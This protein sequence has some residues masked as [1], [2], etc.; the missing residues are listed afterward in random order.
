MRAAKSARR[1]ARVGAGI[2]SALLLA[3]TGAPSAVADAPPDAPRDPRWVD[4]PY[5]PHHTTG[6]NV[7]LGSAV[8]Y[9][10]H[11]TK[12][13]TALGA[14]VAAGPR[15]GRFTFEADYLFLNLSEPGP[16]ALRYGRAQRLGA[17]ARVDVVR[18]GSRVLGANSMLAIYAELGAAR[19]WHAWSR[20]GLRDPARAVPV[21]SAANLGVVGFGVNLD[22]RL[23]QPLNLSR[24]GWQ[25]GWQLT[26]TPSRL[27]DPMVECRG[28]IC[29][30][31]APAP[32]ATSR[33]TAL[34]VTSTIAFTW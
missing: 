21:D 26:S 32:M 29:A 10:V 19:Q 15:I 13:Y 28:G 27:A 24:V 12:T 17:M 16:S 23:E 3:F 18:L 6:T 7:R 31:A 9:L 5:S 4:S 1:L 33:N 22:H 2:T 8:G 34:L 14:A 30:A 20:P 25:L 11:D